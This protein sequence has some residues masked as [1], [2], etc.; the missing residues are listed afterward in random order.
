VLNTTTADG[1][2]EKPL[3][4][5]GYGLPVWPDAANSHRL[6]RQ[7]FQYKGQFVYYA[8]AHTGC[9]VKQ[10][11]QRFERAGIDIEDYVVAL[12]REIHKIVH[13]KV[14]DS[15]SLEGGTI[16][17]KNSSSVSRRLLREI[18]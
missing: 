1:R 11:A 18:F 3:F 13:G 7:P 17:G 2:A 4:C 14:E 12:D 9:T 15:S 16:T 8:Y 6:R 10:F 5:D